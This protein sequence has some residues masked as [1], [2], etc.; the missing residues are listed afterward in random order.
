MNWRDILSESIRRPVTEVTEADKIGTSVTSVTTSL[1]AQITSVEIAQE[2]ILEEPAQAEPTKTTKTL[3]G[4]DPEAPG[5]PYGAWRSAQLNEL[6]RKHGTAQQPGQIQPA[7]VLDGL[8]KL[9]LKSK[10]AAS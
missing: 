7:A 10:A 3:A 1:E 8:T 4:I 9:G 5:I 2:S 6:F